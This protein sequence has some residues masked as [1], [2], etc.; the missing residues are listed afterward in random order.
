M[1]AQKSLAEAAEAMRRGS[2]TDAEAECR[3]IL[4][5]FPRHHHALIFLAELLTRA[6]RATEAQTASERAE[7]SKPG[8]TARFTQQVIEQFRTAFGPAVPPRADAVR[9]G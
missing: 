2:L 3:S 1:D 7:L 8:V 5:V 6:G 4:A 9:A